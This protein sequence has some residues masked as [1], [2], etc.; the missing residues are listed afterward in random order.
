M[1]LEPYLEAGVEQG[2]TKWTFSVNEASKLAL[3]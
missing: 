2:G 1:K 3:P